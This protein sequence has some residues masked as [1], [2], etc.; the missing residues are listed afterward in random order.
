M[1]LKI[2]ST[3]C[4]ALDIGNRNT[5]FGGRMLSWLDEAAA[6]YAMQI[7]NC[8]DLVTYRLAETIFTR[9]V[10]HND[11]LEFYGDNPRKG[12]HSIT[13]RIQVMV[14]G[15]ECLSTECTFVA[16]DSNG[17]KRLIDW[18]NSLIS[19]DDNP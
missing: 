8:P 18:N 19:G 9:P 7:T 16:V 11:I 13:F 4:K 2:T 6:I 10:R 17:N 15:Q 5:L 1:R 14:G 12:R 3:M